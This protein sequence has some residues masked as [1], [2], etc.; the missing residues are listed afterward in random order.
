[1]CKPF[2]CRLAE[3]EGF[4]LRG[5]EFSDYELMIASH[6]VVPADITVS[7][8]DIA[9]LDSVIQELRESVVLPIQHKDLFKHSKHED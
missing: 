6:L 9:G 3:Q 4:K 5:Q 1:M 2:P 8:A 7:W